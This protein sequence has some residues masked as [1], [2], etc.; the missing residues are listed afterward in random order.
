[1]VEVASAAAYEE[2][3]RAA[4]VEPDAAERERMIRE[5]L[6][7][8]GEWSDP[9]GVLREVIHLVEWPFALEGRFDERY[10]S[11]P[12]RVIQA[13]MQKDQRYFPLGRNRFAV[14]ANGGEPELVRAGHEN[15]LE[16][17]LEDASFTFERDVKK[18]IDGLAAELGSITFA[19]AG[20]FADK[21]ERLIQL[22]KRLGGGDASREAA[23]LAKAD[24]A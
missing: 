5:G 8:L 17:R 3:L 18:G 6:D 19:G 2:T 11:L 16:S 9:A 23:R 24:Q 20:S 21:T 1:E 7:A 14:V 15:V 10:L 22:V 12:E 13:P 4:G